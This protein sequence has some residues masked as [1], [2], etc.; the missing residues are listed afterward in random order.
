[1]ERREEQNKED[2]RGREGRKRKGRGGEGRKRR[3]RGSRGYERGVKKK[4][5]MKAAKTDNHDCNVIWEREKRT[6][7]Q[8]L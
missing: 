4:E 5:K 3:R 6:E 7:G 1:M 2:V 8:K